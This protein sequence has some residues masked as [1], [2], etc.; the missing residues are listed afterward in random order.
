M[1][2]TTP[3]RYPNSLEQNDPEGALNTYV[4]DNVANHESRIATL[5]A[6]GGS[7]LVGCM[8]NGSSSLSVTAD[9]LNSPANYITF[10]TEEFDT[11][12]M[13]DT[14]GTASQRQR[15]LIPETAKYR[16]VLENL[17]I[18]VDGVADVYAAFHIFTTQYGTTLATVSRYGYFRQ[19]IPTGGAAI[20]INMNAV[21]SLTAGQSVAVGISCAFP[22]AA[23]TRST[24]ALGTY[25]NSQYHGGFSVIK[26]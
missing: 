18:Y 22:G 4:I 13:F 2:Y 24:Y 11:T 16:L 14:A 19:T 17:P 21:A 23:G 10:T 9:Y 3:V 15:V 8:L 12:N 26:I 20:P 25:P 1:P 5:E 7:S 6:G